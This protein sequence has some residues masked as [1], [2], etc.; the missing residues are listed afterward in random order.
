MTPLVLIPAFFG[1]LLF[2]RRSSRYLPFD[3]ETT[4]LLRRAITRPA[5]ALIDELGGPT[6]TEQRAAC[7]DFVEYFEQRGMFRP[8]RTAGGARADPDQRA[9]ARSLAR[10]ARRAPRDHRGLQPALYA[11]LRR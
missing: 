11:L 7:I 10:A 8:R 9:A 3:H 6:H 1:S 2:D 4:T 5:S